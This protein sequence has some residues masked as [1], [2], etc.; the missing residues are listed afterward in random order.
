MTNSYVAEQGNAGGA[1]INVQI[2]SGTNQF[3]GGGHEFYTSQLLQ[4]RNYFLTNSTL[5]T[6]NVFIQHQYGGEIGGPILKDKLFFFGDYERTT[7]R[8]KAGP[9]V[10]TL[11][12]AAMSHR[13]LP[14]PAGKPGHLRS[15][16]RRRAPEPTKRKSP[17][18]AQLNVICPGRIDPAAA[19]I[20]NAPA[21]RHRDRKPQPASDQNNFSGSG[22]AYFNR[23]DCRHQDQLRSYPGN[24]WS[25]GDTASRRSRLRSAAARTRRWRCHQRRTARQRSRPGA[26][27]RPGCDPHLYPQSSGRLELRLHSPAAGLD[28][29]SHFGQRARHAE[30]PGNQQRGSNGRSKPLLRASGFCLPHGN[31]SPSTTGEMPRQHSGQ[32]PAGQPVPL[33]RPAVR[34]RREPEL[35]PRQA[36]LPWRHR[37]ESQPD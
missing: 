27:H 25:S 18:M 35:E 2:K 29:R 9:D 37:V 19:A 4:A 36:C 13:R 30:N 32:C 10:R 3:H 8:Q 31:A 6:K 26:E 15:A 23:D 16:D 24:T 14:G 21:D 33:P 34:H 20:V 7:Q 12:T 17:A 28:L 22:T 11:P 5:Y 1:A